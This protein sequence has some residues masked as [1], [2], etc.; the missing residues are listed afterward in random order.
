MLSRGCP[1]GQL[2]RRGSFPVRRSTQHHH[3]RQGAG[4]ALR[5]RVVLPPRAQRRADRH[6]TPALRNRP[7]D[8][9][10]GDRSGR[11]LAR[12]QRMSRRPATGRRDRACAHH[13]HDRRVR[14]ALLRGRAG[15]LAGQ[16]PGSA[17]EACSRSVPTWPSCLA[18][19]RMSDCTRCRWA[20]T[21]SCCWW[22]AT[23][24]WSDQIVGER[25]RPRRTADGAARARLRHPQGIRGRSCGGRTWRFAPSWR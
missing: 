14:P 22:G 11:D 3:P 19:M 1:G 16:H 24:P 20:A 4:A 9:R 15:G 10:S 17:R 2:H 21:A 13:G 18:P 12:R 6:R 25:R 8:L 23:H 5:S 7:A